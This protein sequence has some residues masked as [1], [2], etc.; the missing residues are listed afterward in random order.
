[1]PR[2]PRQQRAKA[3]SPRPDMASMARIARWPTADGQ[4]LLLPRAPRTTSGCPGRYPRSRPAASSELRARCAASHRPPARPWRSMPRPDH[5]NR[6]PGIPMKWPKSSEAIR[7]CCG[8]VAR[9]GAQNSASQGSRPRRALLASWCAWSPR[10]RSG[11]P[12]ASAPFRKNPV[13]FCSVIAHYDLI[14][15]ANAFCRS[16]HLGVPSG[17]SAS[18]LQSIPSHSP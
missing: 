12:G 3:P 1:M 6:S 8:E 18:V 17:G 7:R 4:D 16:F 11:A 5:P 2:A 15:A 14:C 10:P 13:L 9:A